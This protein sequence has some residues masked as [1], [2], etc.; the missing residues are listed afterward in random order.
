MSIKTSVRFRTFII[1]TKTV[2]TPTK[3]KR[4]TVKVTKISTSEKPRSRF[5]SHLIG[6]DPL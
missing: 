1:S 3:S 4:R 5:M 6:L 2:K